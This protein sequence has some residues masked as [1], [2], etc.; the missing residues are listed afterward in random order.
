VSP[1]RSGS[2]RRLVAASSLAVTLLA[3]LSIPSFAGAATVPERIPL[4]TGAQPE[5][6]AIAPNGTFFTGSL[7]DGSIFRG[8]L[9]SGAPDLLVTPPAGRVAAG[10][11]IHRGFLYVAGGPTGQGYVYDARSGGTVR[12]FPFRGGF[13]N[14]VVVTRRAAW[15]TDS[16]VPALYRVPVSPTGV[17]G[18]AS[19]VETIPLTGDISF[20]PDFNTNGIDAT[21][22]GRGLI[23]VQSNTGLLFRVDPGTGAT[24][25]IDLGGATVPSGDGILLEGHTLWVVQNTNQLTKIR[26]GPKLASGSVVHVVTDPDLAVPTTVGRKGDHLYVVNA[27]FDVTPTPQTEYWLAVLAAH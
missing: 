7:L 14:D 2:S 8:R 4:P 18:P 1:C 19:S 6:I 9:R 5:G 3:S 17:P 21:P 13:V 22:D 11:K 10:M 25:Q 27:R 26:L 12:V 23:I 16:F 24:V 15:F 20:G